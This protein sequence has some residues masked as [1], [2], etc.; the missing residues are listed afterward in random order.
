LRSL[1]PGDRM[2]LAP[3]LLGAALLAAGCTTATRPLDPPPLTPRASVV[4]NFVVP[5]MRSRMVFLAQQEWELFG[6][7][8]VVREEDGT[9]QVAFPANAT[10]EAQ[11]A[12][13]SRV[14]MYWYAVSRSP[15]VGDQGELEPWSA[16]FI[17]WLAR[18]AGVAPDEFPPTV[19]H[20]D[21]IERF[22]R[23]GDGARF[24]ARDPLLYAP[25]I[26]D[27][28]CVSRSAA[29][30]DFASLRRGPYHCDIVVA[31]DVGA[32]EVVGGNV[33]DAVA[34]AR[35][36]VDGRGLLLPRGDRHWVTV[37]EQRSPR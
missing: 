5:S 6:R 8:V 1:A 23:A 29:V 18:S 32:V 25:R 26:G 31:A 2:Q 37:I 19:L 17:S 33:G 3:F 36:G 34:L 27:L 28:V 13:L 30:T 9:A 22:L 24:I 7:G 21:Y 11:P 12:M 4:P 16:A 10:H 14:L 35:F 20:W 15:I